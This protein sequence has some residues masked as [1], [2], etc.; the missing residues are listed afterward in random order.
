MTDSSEIELISWIPDIDSDPDDFGA[1]VR[2]PK[3]SRGGV[4]PVPPPDLPDIPLEAGTSDD[5]LPAPDYH[6]MRTEHA[7]EARD[8]Q[9]VQVEL[10]LNGAIQSEC[11]RVVGEKARVED[12][13]V[14]P[15]QAAGEA[16]GVHLSPRMAIQQ[17][18]IDVAKQHRREE[19]ER[20]RQ[21]QSTK[22]RSGAQWHTHS[23]DGGHAARLRRWCPGA[24]ASVWERYRPVNSDG[25]GRYTGAPA[26][27]TVF[28]AP[29][30]ARVKRL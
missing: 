24:S 18:G 9:R 17:R 22:K 4:V 16:G 27:H 1:M 5:E 10:G 8:D 11:V 13:K 30:S 2:Q 19:H 23:C 7:V 12:I 28:A 21:E 26:I 29:V 20:E 14:A 3:A 15:G 6:V 25:S